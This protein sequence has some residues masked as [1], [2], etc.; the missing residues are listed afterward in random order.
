MLTCLPG[1][2]HVHAPMRQVS[3]GAPAAH[4]LSNAHSPAED[5]GVRDSHSLLL[6]DLQ[7]A[8]Y[9][10]EVVVADREMVESVRSGMN[11][12]RGAPLLQQRGLQLCLG[13]TG[14]PLT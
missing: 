4:L 3:L 2:L 7:E 12:Q 5:W 13:T 6:G 1:G 11:G 9:G 8:L 10:K 14:S